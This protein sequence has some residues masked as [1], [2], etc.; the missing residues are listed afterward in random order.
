MIKKKINIAFNNV[1]TKTKKLFIVLLIVFFLAIIIRVFLGEPCYVSSASMEPAI[2]SGDWIWVNKVTY[3]SRMPFRW[4][5]IPLLNA[6]THISSLRH[7]DAKIDWGY[8]R[9]SGVKRPCVG[10]IVVF[11]SP[12][13]EE[14]L[15]VK[16]VVK[17]KRTDG[18]LFYDMRG[19]NSEISHDSRFFGQIPEKLIV[20]KVNRTIFSIEK[21]EEDK[22][23]LRFDRFFYKLK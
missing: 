10:D 11:N 18:C 17:I 3:G 22:L 12:E 1:M 7:A 14:L 8:H 16:R 13:N 19:D 9:L 6:F 23:K 21:N 4:A 2:L 5:D 20:G 15:L